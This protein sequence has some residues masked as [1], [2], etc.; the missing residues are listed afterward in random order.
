MRTHSTPTVNLYKPKVLNDKNRTST[1]DVGALTT[2][3]IGIPN[4]INKKEK[5]K[6]AFHP[7]T[8]ML[9]RDIHRLLRY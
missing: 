5:N 3:S 8:Q 2:M 1:P 7:L 4:Q 6:H 9:L